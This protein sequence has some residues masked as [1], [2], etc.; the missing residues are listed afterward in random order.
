[1]RDGNE[2]PWRLEFGKVGMD[3]VEVEVYPRQ[4]GLIGNV[5]ADEEIFWVFESAFDEGSYG[6]VF[7]EELH[8]RKVAGWHCSSLAWVK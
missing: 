3:G 2:V 7:E 8:R 4:G 6:M 1:M 5:G